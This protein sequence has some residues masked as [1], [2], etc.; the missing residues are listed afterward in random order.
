MKGRL[1]ISLDNPDTLTTRDK[2]RIGRILS[3]KAD[4]LICSAKN[5]TTGEIDWNAAE[6]VA[7]GA[8]ECKTIITSNVRDSILKA[9]ELSKKEI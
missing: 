6:E 8:K 4:I 7:R 2:F 1:I 9:I 5:E 3:K